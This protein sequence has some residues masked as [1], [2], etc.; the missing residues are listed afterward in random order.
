MQDSSIILQ[1]VSAQ[2]RIRNKRA[3][4]CCIRRHT[5]TQYSRAPEYGPPAVL[6]AL[7]RTYIR[8]SCQSPQL[9][10]LQQQHY[11]AFIMS[12][13]YVFGSRQRVYTVNPLY[14]YRHRARSL[15]PW[16]LR[17]G[18]AALPSLSHR[19]IHALHRRTG[20]F[21]GTCWREKEERGRIRNINQCNRGAL[22]IIGFA[23]WQRTSRPPALFLVRND[24]RSLSS[25]LSYF[26]WR[27]KGG[28]ILYAGW[29][30]CVHGLKISFLAARVKVVFLLIIALRS[31]SRTWCHCLLLCHDWKLNPFLG[32]KRISR[33]TRPILRS[34]AKKCSSSAWKSGRFYLAYFKC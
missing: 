7:A 21:H 20:T 3:E 30:M 16:D 34:D 9:S 28:P 29:S 22:E 33:R 13:K 10:R 24:Y 4:K 26:A 23:S 6:P 5:R 12:G 17:R 15:A 19:R 27:K 14:A 2:S 18:C 25:R 11:T 31:F 1:K 32:G 8:G